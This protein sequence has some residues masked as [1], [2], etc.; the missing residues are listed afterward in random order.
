MMA[1]P[2]TAATPDVAASDIHAPPGVASIALSPEE[3]QARVFDWFDEHGRKH[4]P[5]QENTTPYRVW[6]SEIM[7]QQTQ[8]TTVLPYYARFM[9]RFPDV[10]ALA[11]A[12]IDEVLHL[13]TGLGYYARARNLHKAAQQ[14]V[15]EHGGAFPVESVE[16]LSA[17][18]G[19]GR[20]TAGAIISISTG[21]RAP[22]LDGNVKR[23]LARLHAVEGWPG[24]PA[25]ERKLW[26]LAERYT[27]QM[28]LADWTQAMMDLG[29]TLCT[30]G[31]KPD[32]AR[33]PFK[34]VC[35]A[36]ARGEEKRFPESKP[37]KAIP[38]RQTL[39]L[40]VSDEAGRILLER[41]PPT[42]IWGGLWAPPLV[43]DRE[44][45]REW[46]AR[47]ARGAHLEA[48]LDSFEHVFSHFRLTITPQPVQLGAAELTPSAEDGVNEHGAGRRFVDPAAPDAVGLPA[49]VK[50][51]LARC[52][53]DLFGL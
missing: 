1:V 37:K 45:A 7:L 24:R 44:A 9:E 25:V 15:A 42:G 40:L 26:A 16:A 35:V 8:V 46:V 12:E 10:A 51:L 39:M 32:C 23:V 48:P 3:F 6:V 21:Q 19:I 5:W 52:T 43:E 13:W 29:A 33:C 47:E 17:L 18:P 31:S 50:A 20:S 49:P 36:H 53:D 34:E 41:R 38:T 11:A 14:V 28:R 4:L 30:R 27:P 22:I 2:D